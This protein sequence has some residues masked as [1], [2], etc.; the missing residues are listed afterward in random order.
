MIHS[1][2]GRSSLMVGKGFFSRVRDYLD[3]DH[4]RL[5][6]RGMVTFFLTGLAL[7]GAALVSIVWLVVGWAPVLHELRH[8]AG[9]CLIAAGGATIA[10][11]VGS[12]L[13]SREVAR[14]DDGP[15]I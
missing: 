6:P 12:L 9:I 4:R 2:R 10:S 15:E 13:A 3:A 8:L 1:R 11:H 14:H 5:S 7:A